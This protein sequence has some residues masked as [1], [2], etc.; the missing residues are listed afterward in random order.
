MSSLRPNSTDILFVSR[1]ADMARVGLSLP[2]SFCLFCRPFPP[3]LSNGRRL[4][5]SAKS[6]GSRSDR[7][8]TS[9]SC[10][11]Y[12]VAVTG[13]PIFGV[14]PKGTHMVD[15]ERMLELTTA[16]AA[17][18]SGRRSDTTDKRLWRPGIDNVGCCDAVDIMTGAISNKKLGKNQPEMSPLSLKSD[19]NRPDCCRQSGRC[20][21]RG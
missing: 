7:A 16:P 17:S 19:A 11:S 4:V 21:L 20:L 8:A 12:G 13:R 9:C 18:G 2:P 5:K 1:T 10:P 14:R 3:V 15:Y 6:L